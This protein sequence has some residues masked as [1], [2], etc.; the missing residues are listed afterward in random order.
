MRKDM[1]S[2]IHFSPVR[3]SKRLETTQNASE[4]NQFN[5]VLYSHI[6]KFMQL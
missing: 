4:V 5:K 2:D 1:H 3:N 6:M